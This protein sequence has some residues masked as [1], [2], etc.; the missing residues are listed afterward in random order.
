MDRSPNRAVSELRHVI[1]DWNVITDFI[2]AEGEVYTAPGQY[3]F[4][5]IIQDKVVSGT[6][7]TPKLKQKSAILFFHRSDKKEIEMASVGADGHLWRMIGPENSE[8]RTT[9]NIVRPDG[10]QT[11]L[12]FTRSDVAPNSFKSMMELSD[13]G[14][15][16]WRIANRQKFTRRQDGDS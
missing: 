16:T 8:T 2:S 9:P 12:R 5:W 6:A 13:D 7:I 3:S 15:E 1:G 11:M 10:S 4:R 14:G